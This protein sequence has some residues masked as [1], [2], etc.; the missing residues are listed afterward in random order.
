MSA[1][2]IAVGV[3]EAARIARVE[4]AVL[5]KE[6]KSMKRHRQVK[7]QFEFDERRHSRGDERFALILTEFEEIPFSSD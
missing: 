7:G 1:E 3:A 6:E 5:Q 4:L 2:G